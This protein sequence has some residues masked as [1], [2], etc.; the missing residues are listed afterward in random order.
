MLCFFFILFS[1]SWL[2]PEDFLLSMLG[3][4][5]EDNGANVKIMIAQLIWS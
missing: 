4:N 3:K 1:K 2:W 5:P